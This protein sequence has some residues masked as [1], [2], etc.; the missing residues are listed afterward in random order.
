[1][2][3]HFVGLKRKRK[4]YI[5]TYL[6]AETILNG[7]FFF[8]FVCSLPSRQD[9]FRLGGSRKDGSNK[10]GT[11][12]SYEHR[13]NVKS[14]QVPD[15]F[16][17]IVAPRGKNAAIARALHSRRHLLHVSNCESNNDKTL[18]P[19][20][21]HNYNFIFGMRVWR[22]YSCFILFRKCVRGY[23]AHC[24]NTLEDLMAYLIFAWGQIL[25]F[26]RGQFSKLNI[27][28]DH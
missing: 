10:S 24:W 9:F 22:N 6:C 4:I 28:I 5:C 20:L 8:L 26:S 1:M 25:N 27:F 14:Q 17:Y 19:A 3:L 11:W 21:P 12:R 23:A 18:L 7:V 13:L 15:N 2:R 16:R